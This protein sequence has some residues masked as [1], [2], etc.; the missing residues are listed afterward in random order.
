ML[1]TPSGA[2]VIFHAKFSP[3]GHWIVYA[4]DGLYVQPFPGPGLRRQIGPDGAN[5]VGRNGFMSIPV[6][7][8]RGEPQFGTPTVLFSPKGMRPPPGSFAA[9]IQW[10]VSRDGS[11]I[12]WLQGEEQPGWPPG[13]I[14][15]RTNAVK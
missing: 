6:S 10:A 7:W 1:L 8:A 9:A 4:Q 3:D 2:R 5:P 15:V 14:D 13:V 11:Q 12:Y